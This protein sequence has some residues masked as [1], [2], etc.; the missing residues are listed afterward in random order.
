MD[1]FSITRRD[2]FSNAKHPNVYFQKLFF[3]FHTGNWNVH[4][5]IK[6]RGEGLMKLYFCF[7]RS[8]GRLRQR[9][10]IG[11]E[12]IKRK[13]NPVNVQPCSDLL[14]RF[15]LQYRIPKSVYMQ[16]ERLSICFLGQFWCRFVRTR[17]QRSAVNSSLSA[18]H[19]VMN[20]RK[21]INSTYGKTTLFSNSN[22]REKV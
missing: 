2:V 6:G 19:M 1:I 21:N 4:V 7:F 3:P 20:K 8:T 17:R 22:V 16:Q 14:K 10:L 15:I 9:L 5:G 11:L 13:T 12:Y 18:H